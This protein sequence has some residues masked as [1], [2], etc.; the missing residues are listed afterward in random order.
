[1]RSATNRCVFGLNIRSS[2]ASRYHDGSRLPCWSLYRF[3][4]ALHRY[5]A[6]RCC[7]DCVL[8]LCCSVS[9]RI[10]HSFFRHPQETMSVG[11]Q[12]GSLFI[13]RLSEE[14]VAYRFTFGWRHSCHKGQASDPTVTFECGDHG[15]GVRV[16]DKEDWPRATL[17]KATFK[18][19]TS[20]D[21]EVI[22]IWAAITLMSALSSGPIT[23]DHEDASAHAACTRTIVALEGSFFII[24]LSLI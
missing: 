24:N 16:R 2:S 8:L 11:F 15:A 1:M 4:K 12:M 9:N 19:A 6:L 23:A 3:A 22:G 20:S 21:S 17:S 18:A 14:E 5:R 7:P 13:W 10:L